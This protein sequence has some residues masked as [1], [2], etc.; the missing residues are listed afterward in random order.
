MRG[1]LNGIRDKNAMLQSELDFIQHYLQIQQQRFGYCFSYNITVDTSVDAGKYKVP[2]LLLQPVVENAIEHGIDKSRKDGHIAIAV[3]QTDKA[4]VITVTDNGGGL[5]PGF[6]LRGNHA[7]TIIAERLEL[8][9]R[10]KGTGGF[11]IGPN[12]GGLP[13]TCVTLLLAKHDIN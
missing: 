1:L 10:M 5:P 13:G 4:L 2:T 11:R 3:T 8:L 12:P 6:A 7:L 9:A